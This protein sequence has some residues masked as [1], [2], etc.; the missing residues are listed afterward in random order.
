[1]FDKEEENEETRGR[2]RYREYYE[3]VKGKRE[4]LQTFFLAAF[5]D[6]PGK[7]GFSNGVNR[8]F[9]R[10]SW[11]SIP[12]GGTNVCPARRSRSMHPVI[13]R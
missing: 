3:N 11:L 1:M 10:E 5:Q 2:T 12:R 13:Q 4:E 7:I 8:K 9:T 6:L